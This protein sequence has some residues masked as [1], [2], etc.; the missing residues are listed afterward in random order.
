MA[1]MN[2]NA[3]KNTNVSIIHTSGIVPDGRG[4]HQIV[5]T[6]LTATLYSVNPQSAIQRLENILSGEEKPDGETIEINYHY[7][8]IGEV[9]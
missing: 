6:H 7:E 4:G 8:Q 9:K 1:Q 3:D 5:H 2:K